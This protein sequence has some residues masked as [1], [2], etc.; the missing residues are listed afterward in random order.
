M[1][2]KLRFFHTFFFDALC[3]ILG[4]NLSAR[5]LCRVVDRQH[6]GGMEYT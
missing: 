4:F 5:N 2:P 6:A 3:V 1:P